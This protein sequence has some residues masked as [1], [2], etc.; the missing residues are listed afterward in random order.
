MWWNFYTYSIYSQ[1][2]WRLSL[3]WSS[4]H[5]PTHRQVSSC[6]KETTAM[7]Q[8]TIRSCRAPGAHPEARSLFWVLQKEVSSRAPKWLWQPN[9]AVGHGDERE[10]SKLH[11]LHCCHWCGW[12]CPL[13][14]TYLIGCSASHNAFK[15]RLNHHFLMNCIAVFPVE[16]DGRIVT[17]M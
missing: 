9:Q 1:E 11:K 16:P 4:R 3:V 17:S 5:P 13:K 2:M 10:I 7:D 8:V 6:L 15:P 14:R 12:R